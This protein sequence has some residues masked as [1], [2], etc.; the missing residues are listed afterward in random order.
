M[1]K[2]YKKTLTLSVILL[3][4]CA[5]LPVLGNAE[6]IK[7]NSYEVETCGIDQNL[8]LLRGEHYLYFKAIKNV[9][10]SFNIKYVF[11]AE[12][13]YQYP[14]YL[15]ILNDTN[16]DIANYKIE[17]DTNELNKIVNFTINSMNNSGEKL[18]H[19]NCWVLVKNYDYENL[20]GFVEIPDE[21]M[22]PEEVKKWLKPSEVVQS[23][24]LLLRLKA[25][26]LKLFTN[27][28]LLKLAEKIAKFCRQHRYILFLLQ[29][30][31]QG[32]IGYRSQDA[33]TT[34]FINGECPGRS[35][36]GC[37]LF[38]A[39]QVPA[40][41]LLA[42]PA[43]YDF[44]FE[45]H[46]MTEY[47]CPGFN[48]IPTEVHKGVTPYPPQNQ[49]VLRVCY[50]IDENNTQTDF[51]FDKMKGLERWIWI[52]NENVTPYY[53]DLKEGSK[54]RAYLENSVTVDLNVAND[55]IGLTHEVF[56]K[57]QYYLSRELE[58]ENLYHFKNATGYIM[59]AINELDNSDDS[60][61][62]IYYLNKANDEFNQIN[63]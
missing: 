15:E 54:I 23:D 56:N 9:S 51:L 2:T 32:I 7:I 43:R 25:K 20:P 33:L 12:Y 39:N 8:T 29:Y 30:Y 52:N 60:F 28:N 19:F 34:L 62:Y 38:R 1:K 40:R 5:S 16:M 59:Q 24:N 35:H 36:L 41:V 48:W 13:N 27:N 18:I 61:G 6:Y 63:I 22:L 58:E 4:F 26:Q 49:I 53:K 17:N 14:I 37:A 31:L 21:N 44:W 3:L 45:M 55:T 57:Y 42:M 50:P 10:S 11:P 46:Y 47:Y